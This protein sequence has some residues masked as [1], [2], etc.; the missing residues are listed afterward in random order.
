MRNKFVTAVL[1]FCATLSA[2]A[3]EDEQKVQVSGAE[4]KNPL[5]QTYQGY[6]EEFKRGASSQI[7]EKDLRRIFGEYSGLVLTGQDNTELVNAIEGRKTSYFALKELRK[8]PFYQSNI[9]ALLQSTNPY[10]RILAYITVASAGDSSF[11]NELMKAAKTETFKAGKH[12]A[13]LALLYL[14]DRRTSDLFDFLIENEDFND[15]HMMPFYMALD[16]NSLRQTA[17]E[18]IQ[19]K[20]P[21]ARIVAVQS[22]SVT[23]L[24]PSTE[25]VVKQAVKSWDPSNRGY[26][27]Y[28]LKALGMGNLKELLAPML[29]DKAIRDISLQALA[30]SPTPADQQY[31][32]S[33]IPSKG[34]VPEDILDAFFTSTSNDSVKKWLTL[35]RDHRIAPEYTFF[36]SDQPLLTSD[37]MLDT[38]KDTIRKTR[39][40]KILEEL[41]RALEGRKDRDS[42]NLLIQLL[43]DS[44]S[45]VRYWAAH[46]LDGNTSE[47]LQ[48]LLPNLIRD[49]K[50]RTVALTDLAI[51][52][53]MDG[54]QE[55]YE[56]LLDS[57]TKK[58]TDWYRSSLEY[59]SEFPRKKDQSL[60]KSILQSDK[61]AFIK[62]FAVAGLGRLRDE[63]SVE[64]IESALRKEPP[65][66]L[67]ALTYL[68]AFGRIKG[69][70][71]KSIVESYKNSKNDSVHNLVSRLLTHW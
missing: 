62:R 40:H 7:S 39:N 10:Q 47:Q 3:H 58:S 28:T 13:G 67:N 1:L 42:V 32:S 31:L 61:D 50:T 68:A 41:P 18:K 57:D 26:A 37:N 15:A 38:V 5:S 19:S 20:N 24:N 8:E 12:W 56:S 22:L 9:T 25:K 71:A 43:S 70:K 35:I 48:Q 4:S 66:D 64:L 51:Q 69:D 14:G 36:V 30:N 16:K 65:N 59:L 23:G 27:I 21:Q 49:P 33:L 54:L 11:N 60:F 29:K 63:S 55:V 46:S 34:Q 52:N 44:D 6:V 2:Y 53:K 17:Y 45:S